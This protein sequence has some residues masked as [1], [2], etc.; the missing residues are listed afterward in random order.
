MLTEYEA[1]PAEAVTGAVVVARAGTMNALTVTTETTVPVSIPVSANLTASAAST[2]LSAGTVTVAGVLATVA[3]VTAVPFI[4]TAIVGTFADAGATERKEPA[5]A[6]ATS[7]DS[8]LIK[9]S[10]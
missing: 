8:F 6:A 2:E 7:R 1:A 5:N 4:D 9:E 3:V 10:P